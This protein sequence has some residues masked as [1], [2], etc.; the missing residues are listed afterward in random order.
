L[1]ELRDVMGIAGGIAILIGMYLLIINAN[2]TVAVINALSAPT[3][4][5]IKTLQGR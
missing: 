4:T 5:A 3:L 2:K 1:L